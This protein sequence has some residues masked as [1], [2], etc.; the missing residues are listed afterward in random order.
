MP[1]QSPALLIGVSARIY[2]P[3]GPVLDLGGVWTKT[4]HF[5]EQSVAQWLMRGGALPV[6]VPAVDAQSVVQTEELNLGHYAQALDGLV[7]QGGNDVAPASYGEVPIAPEWAGDPVRDAYEKSLIE[8]F[9]KAGKPVFG[10]C[11]GLQMLNVAF[12][13]TMWQDIG[14]QMPQALPHVRSEMYERNVHALEIVPGTHMAALYPG[15]QHGMINSIHHQSIKDLAPDFVVE[16]HCPDDGVIEAIRRRGPG[17]VA[18]VQWHPEFRQKN[19][20]VIFDD[21][22]LLRDFLASARAQQSN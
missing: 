12:G 10:I 22:P 15:L 14:T 19:C 7:L 3:S 16:A 9:V 4:L 21:T 5:L 6:M 18:G 8:A 1:F 13:G 2:Y 20:Q 11:R 17:F